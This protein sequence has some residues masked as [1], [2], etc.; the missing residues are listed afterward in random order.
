MLTASGWT[1]QTRDQINLCVSLGVAIAELTFKTGEPDHTLFVDSRA[2]GTV[3]AKPEGETLTGVEEQS[4][5]YVTGV[6]FGL[7]AW[8]SPLPFSYEST[9]AETFFTNRLDPDPLQPPRVLVS[10]SRNLAR[11]G[12][13]GKATGP[14]PARIPCVSHGHSVAGANSGYH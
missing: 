7:P 12:A 1:V 13:T 3:E 6:P 5:K 10:S 8:K 14:T 9:G 2:I 11:L 4:A